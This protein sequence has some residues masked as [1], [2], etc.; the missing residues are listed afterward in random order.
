MWAKIVMNL[1]S[2]AL[3]FTFAGG[4]TVS[5]RAGDGAAELVVSDTGI[6]IDAAD[7]ERLFERFHRVIGARSRTFEG[8]G[9]GLALVAELAELHGGSVAVSS[10]PGAGLLV[11][12]RRSRSAPSTCP[13]SRSRRGDRHRGSGSPRGSW[14]RRCAGW[15]RRTPSLEARRRRPPDGAGGRRQRRHARLHRVAA[16][17]PVPRADGARRCGRAG[18]GARRAARACRDRRDDAQPRRLRAARGRCR[19]IPRRPTSR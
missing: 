8:T 13:P 2:N 19:P 14:P 11:R 6:G 17:E 5:L 7:Q 4:I 9:I 10:V 16:G 3:K 1:L 12:G 15:T 18:A